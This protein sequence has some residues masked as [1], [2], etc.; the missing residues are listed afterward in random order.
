MADQEPG[1]AI[2]PA[3]AKFDEVT[4]SPSYAK[5]VATIR[6]NYCNFKIVDNGAKLEFDKDKFPLGDGKT[7]VV[8]SNSTARVQ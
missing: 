3:V 5:G 7:I 8:A 6:V 2:A 1:T 4:I